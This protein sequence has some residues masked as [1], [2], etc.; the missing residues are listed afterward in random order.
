LSEV[1]LHVKHL[2]KFFLL[3]DLLTDLLSL[4]WNQKATITVK[5]VQSQPCQSG[6]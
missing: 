2:S 1:S 5:Q 6:G 3:L 4:I